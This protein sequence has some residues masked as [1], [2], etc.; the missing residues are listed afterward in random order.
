MCVQF[1][2][3]ASMEP[4]IAAEGLSWPN[5]HF[6]KVFENHTISVLLNHYF[7]EGLLYNAQKCLLAAYTFFL[8][9]KAIL[10]VDVS[11]QYVPNS[12]GTRK[13][14]VEQPNVYI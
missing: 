14:E 1:V 12:S 6:N 13:A 9:E 10:F 7:R 2:Q 11:L 4:A 8:K 3:N 5:E